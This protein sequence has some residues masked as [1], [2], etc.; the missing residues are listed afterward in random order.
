MKPLRVLHV[1]GAMNRG[2]VE[3]WLLFAEQFDLN[4]VG[5]HL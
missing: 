3:T 5:E 1:L 4:Q 2:G